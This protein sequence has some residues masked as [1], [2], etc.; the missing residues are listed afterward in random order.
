MMKIGVP[1]N[2]LMARR[3][4]RWEQGTFR[5]FVSDF[6]K[7]SLKL[8]YERI[9]LPKMHNAWSI[10]KIGGIN[11]SFTDNLTDHLLLTDDDSTLLIFHHASFLECHL[12]PFS[13]P[14]YPADLVHE[15][16]STIA[17]LFPQSEFTLTTRRGRFSRNSSWLR[18][19]RLAHEQSGQHPTGIDPRLSICGTLQANDRQIERF[20]FWRD[21]W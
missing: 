17:L 13:A 7:E 2:Q 4:L 20:H 3:F 6:F 1:N 8:S 18:K 14:L 10:N 15:T 19:L 21:S 9:R 5:D 16:L 11:I 12:Q